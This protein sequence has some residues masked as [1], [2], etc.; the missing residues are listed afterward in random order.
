M[1][2]WG[3][4]TF[5]DPCRVCE[6][7]WS[8]PEAGAREMIALAPARFDELIGER[9]GRERSPEL[10][11]SAGGY[12]CHVADSLRVWAERIANVALGD[13]GPV[14]EYDQDMLAVA[15][16]YATVGVKGALWS[17]AR[18]VGD[19]EAALQLTDGRN[20]AMSHPELGVMT[21]LDVILIRAHDVHHHARDIQ[22]SVTAPT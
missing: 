10:G 13:A 7:D 15:R 6:F 8:I 16:F 18:A 20:F 21:L 19:W 17:L 3:R 9:D 4:E 22:R 2:A 1:S 14:A 11:W 12:T 5:G